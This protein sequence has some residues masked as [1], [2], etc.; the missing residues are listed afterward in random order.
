MLLIYYVASPSL[1]TH[2]YAGKPVIYISLHV[3]TQVN[4]KLITG[5]GYRSYSKSLRGLLDAVT[6]DSGNSFD[7]FQA[8][9]STITEHFQ[10]KT[11][12]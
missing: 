9:I 3:H 7:G 4:K 8:L 1:C 10:Q 2:V 6:C 11:E 12:S 5:C